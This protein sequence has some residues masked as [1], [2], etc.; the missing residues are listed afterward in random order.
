GTVVLLSASYVSPSAPHSPFTPSLH[1]ALPI[2]HD[3]DKRRI[4]GV[5]VVKMPSAKQ[6]NA[7]GLKVVGTHLRVA[8]YLRFRRFRLRSAQHRSEEHT[9][10]LQ[11]PDHLVCSLHLEKKSKQGDRR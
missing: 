8:G 5:V 2:F 6:R 7:H 11:S 10:E 4:H 9:S 1:D 3:G